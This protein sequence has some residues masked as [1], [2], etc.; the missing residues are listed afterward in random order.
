MIVGLGGTGKSEICLKYAETHRCLHSSKQDAQTYWGVFWLDAR[1][2]SSAEQ[3]FTEV[4]RQCGLA[5]QKKENVMSYLAR[6]QYRWL[7]IIDNAD[8]L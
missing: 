3:S 2:T 8:D 6:V 5:E 4:G 1:T 7:L